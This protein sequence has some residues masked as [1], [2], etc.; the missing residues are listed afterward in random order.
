MSFFLFEQA[1]AVATMIV[2][3]DMMVAGEDKVDMVVE[4]IE[5]HQCHMKTSLSQLKVRFAFF[6]LW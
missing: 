6:V 5:D 1:V 2:V 4:I 3:V